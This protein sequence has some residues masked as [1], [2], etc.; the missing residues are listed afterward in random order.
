MRLLS[1]ENERKKYRNVQV[2]AVRIFQ[3]QQIL[4]SYGKERVIIS[5]ENNMYKII[6]IVRGRKKKKKEKEEKKYR[7]IYMLKTEQPTFKL[8]LIYGMYPRSQNWLWASFRWCWHSQVGST[9]TQ[10]QPLSYRRPMYLNH[11]SYDQV[12]LETVQVLYSRGVG[13]NSYVLPP[14]LPLLCDMPKVA[15]LMGQVTQIN[16]GMF[17]RRKNFNKDFM[18]GTGIKPGRYLS[19][20]YSACIYYIL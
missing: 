3:H 4:P 12:L 19:A 18:G 8:N 16:H 6:N 2:L 15:A 14:P 9:S 5:T 1:V 13:T 11:I 10:Q 17:L 20:L 7:L